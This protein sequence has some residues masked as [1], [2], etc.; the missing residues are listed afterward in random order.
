MKCIGKYVSYKFW[1][2]DGRCY[3]IFI[4]WCCA[5]TDVIAIYVVVDGKPHGQM[6]LPLLSKWQMLLPFFCVAG[7]RPVDSMLQHLLVAYVIAKWQME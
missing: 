5:F 6:L 4:G 2:F 1:F 7:G 3:A